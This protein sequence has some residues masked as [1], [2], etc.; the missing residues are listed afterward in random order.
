[1]KSINEG[2]EICEEIGILLKEAPSK[3]K[4]LIRG[5]EIGLDM[6]DVLKEREEPTV[7]PS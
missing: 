7:E 4:L 6:A 5:I 2:R 3:K 1:M